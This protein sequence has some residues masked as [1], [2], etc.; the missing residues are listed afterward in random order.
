MQR[1]IDGRLISLQYRW[2]YLNQGVA[3]A[4]NALFVLIALIV[5]SYRL[6]RI[7][8]TLPAFVVIAILGGFVAPVGKDLVTAIQQL[9]ARPR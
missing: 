1:A 8:G 6:G 4:L 5:Q 2:K 3:F 9:R 7:P